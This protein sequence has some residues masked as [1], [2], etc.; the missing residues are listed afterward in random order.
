M[1]KRD[2]VEIVALADPDKNMMAMARSLILKYNK[3]APLE[4]GNGPYDYRNLLK[5]DNIDAVFV[6]SPWEWHLPHGTE[7]MQAGKVV[8]MEVC[9][10]GQ[11]QDCWDFVDVSEKTKVPL[12]AMENVCYR[13]DIMAAFNLVKQGLLGEI[14]HLQG[15]YQHDL[16][17]VLF[18]DG[19]DP[20]GPGVEFG[21]KGVSEA[22][23]R[24]L[25]HANRNGDLYPTHGLGPVA[26]MIDINR[27]NRL[28]R[29]SS[30]ATK[31]RG[32]RRYIANHPKGGKNHPNALVD[33]KLGDIVTTQIQTENGETIVLTHDTS[34]PRPY[35]LGF[36]I[37]GTNGLWQDHRAGQPDAGYIE[38]HT[39][40]GKIPK[41]ICR[42]LII[43][44][45]RTLK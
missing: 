44:C 19:I 34:S 20:Y 16:R 41:S 2:D 3:K 10:A 29:L 27:G 11:L 18:N 36:R 8:A 42:N 26:S 28:L 39:T 37:Q 4:F 33:F 14:L 43:P 38:V 6:S 23:W 13:R 24:T 40:G 32:L 21:A 22:R 1:L 7:A 12:M 45:G 9:G 15:G 25:H 17:G 5:H 30:M 35:N 31:S